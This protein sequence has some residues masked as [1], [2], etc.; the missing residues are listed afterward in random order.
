[1]NNIYV[2]VWVIVSW[3]E[4]LSILLRGNVVILFA[5]K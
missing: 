5:K 2:C 3:V 1:M 4:F